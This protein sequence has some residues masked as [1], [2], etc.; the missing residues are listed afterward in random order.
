MQRYALN[1]RNRPP[2]LS[3]TGAAFV[4]KIVEPQIIYPNQ[5][6]LLAPVVADGTTFPMDQPIIASR[7]LYLGFQR[8]DNRLQAFSNRHFHVMTR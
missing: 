8:R 3:E 2:I 4:A 5:P 7:T 1:L 6:K